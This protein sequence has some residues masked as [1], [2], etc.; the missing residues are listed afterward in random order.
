M[1]GE[2]VCLGNLI[3]DDIVFADGTTRMG[4]AGGAMLYA[5][6]GARLW[7][8]RVA[9]VAPLGDD[10]P[11]ETL[12][13]LESRGV[14]LSG[15]RP[16]RRPGLRT[17]LLYEPRARRVVHRLGSPA[18]AEASP[19]PEDVANRFAD[20]RAFHL[21]P[22]PLESQ[23]PLVESLAQR[24]G[25]LLSLDPHDPVREDNLDAWREVLALL[26]VF[27]VSEE[28]LQLEGAARDPRAA[29]ARL[30]GGRLKL[31][32]LKRGAG[33]GLL[34][35]ARAN[36]F[37]EWP[38]RARDVVDPTGAGDAFAGGFLAGLLEGQAVHAALEQGIVAASFALET[39]GAA[40][41][42]AAAPAEARLRQR[43]WF[44]MKA[45]T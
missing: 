12:R 24:A 35:D 10:Y 1:S 23:R 2:L 33:G 7:D 34:F 26:D 29:L 11:R 6:L 36:E 39:W 28:E 14:D 22:T 37:I 38:A 9:I 21:S 43:D 4:Q 20:A 17:W 13:A 8:A 19:R 31:V 41:L 16:L 42:L 27:F 32:L 30:A 44:A 18:H 15:L 3:V 45:K 5:A 25:A 40:G